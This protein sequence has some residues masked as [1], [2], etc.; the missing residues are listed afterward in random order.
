LVLPFGPVVL[1][2]LFADDEYGRAVLLDR[3]VQRGLG[4]TLDLL[5]DAARRADLRSTDPAR[6]L[7]EAAAALE[8]D[9]RRRWQALKTAFDA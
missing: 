6:R 9:N 1:G 2:E 8:P 5:T 3:A 4:S 7:L